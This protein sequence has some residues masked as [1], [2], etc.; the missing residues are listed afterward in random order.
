MF[1]ASGAAA[2]YRHPRNSIF[3]LADGTLLSPSPTLDLFCLAGVMRKKKK[4]KNMGGPRN[5]IDD[6]WK[7]EKC[8][9]P[10]KSRFNGYHSGV[11]KLNYFNNK[12]VFINN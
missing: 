4:E 2:R 11:V 1:Y 6:S 8:E 10:E 9:N 7:A 3:K 5:I 12:N